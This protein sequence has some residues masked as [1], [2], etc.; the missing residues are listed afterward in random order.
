MKFLDLQF[1]VI[2]LEL[3]HNKRYNLIVIFQG[4]YLELAWKEGH[5]IIDNF[6]QM[7][8][9]NLLLNGFLD[10]VLFVKQIFACHFPCDNRHEFKNLS[11]C[12]F[13][14]L[15]NIKHSLRRQYSRF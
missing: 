10:S 1:S 6:E 8:F 9:L 7:S 2:F 11:A 15:T 14:F 3:P 13:G 4:R 12:L 5:V